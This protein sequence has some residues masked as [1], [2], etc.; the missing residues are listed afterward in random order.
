MPAIARHLMALSNALATPAT[1]TTVQGDTP[2]PTASSAPSGP[3]L[4]TDGYLEGGAVTS[5]LAQFDKAGGGSST[6]TGARDAMKQ[7]YL[8][9]DKFKQDKLLDDAALRSSNEESAATATAA[10]DQAKERQK[11]QAYGGRSSTILTSPLG[12]PGGNNN[13]AAAGKTLLG[14]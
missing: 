5:T 4:T 13:P 12:V 2:A 8:Q 9:S 1:Q 10:R 6:F 14:Q 3:K 11:Q 7:A